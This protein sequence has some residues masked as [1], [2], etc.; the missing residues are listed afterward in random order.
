MRA[1]V[2]LDLD[3]MA[4]PERTELEALVRQADFFALRPQYRAPHPD[5]FQYSITVVEGGYRHQVTVDERAAPGELKPLLQRLGESARQSARG[6]VPG[7]T[8]VT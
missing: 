6:P 1:L 3:Q 2:R 7:D 8:D 4:E 5:A